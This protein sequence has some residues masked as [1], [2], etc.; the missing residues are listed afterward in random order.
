ML[1]HDDMRAALAILVVC[2]AGPAIAAAPGVDPARV[3]AQAHLR[4]GNALLER[5]LPAEALH[6]FEEAY[7]L[8]PSPKLH[9]NLGQAHSLIPGHEKQA[10]DEMSR[11]LTEARDASPE[12]RAA[13]QAVCL[14]LRAQVGLVPAAPA[15]APPLP[16][17]ASPPPTAPGPQAS[18]PAPSLARIALPAGA[19]PDSDG[20]SHWTR[21]HEIGAGLAALGA[22]SLVFG[23]V[24]HIRYFGKADDFRK[25]GC[26]TNDLSV[27]SNCR[28]LDDQFNGAHVGWIAGYLGAAALGGAGAYLL[29]IAPPESTGA[30]ESGP[31]L[32]MNPGV[33]LHFQG[34]F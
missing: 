25:A 27:G 8:F 2:F 33:S 17:I 9:Y 14:R 16:P 28:A 32:S 21:R 4:E 6:R 26:G 15:P 12:L 5:G 29:W 11:F 1:S 24:E 20:H 13:A 7:R 22:A 10:Y 30:P 19:N 34:R 23:L 18:A 3:Q 31:A